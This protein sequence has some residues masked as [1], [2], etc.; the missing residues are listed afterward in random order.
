MY[1]FLLAIAVALLVVVPLLV[2]KKLKA[3]LIVGAAFG[4][5]SLGMCYAIVW[6]L[7]WPFWGFAGF[8]VLLGWAVSVFIV[9]VTDGDKY[10]WTEENRKG[11]ILR[12]RI[13]VGFLMAGVGIFFVRFVAT[14]SMFRAGD[15]ARMIGPVVERVWTQDVQPTSP[16]HVRLVPRELA[17]FLADKQLGTVSGAIGSQ[18]QVSHNLITLQFIKGEYWYVAPLD[19]R[20]FFIWLNTNSTPGYV[21]V[22]GEDP[23]RPVKVIT[24]EKFIYT[25]GAFFG[26]SL[27]RHIWESGYSH[28]VLT[29]YSL[30]V[31]E[32]GK[33]W[34]VVTACQP[35]IGWSGE[36]VRGVIVVDPTSGACTF[37]PMGSVPDWIDRVVPNWIAWDYLSWRGSY[38]NGFWNSVF[39]SKN[40]TK[41]E[42]PTI[43]Y[44]ANHEPLW[45]SCIT[46]DSAS[47]ES[48]IGLV[49]V[50]SRTGKAVE[51]RAA[52][53]TESAVLKAVNNKISFKKWHGADPVLYNIY[54]TMAS[55][56]P[57]LGESG[58]FQGVA[59][60]N[61]KDSQVAIGDDAASAFRGYQQILAQAGNQISPDAARMRRQIEGMVDRF[62]SDVK[63]SASTYY[64]HIKDVPHLFVGGSELSPKLPMTQV[65]DRVV[66][67][68]IDSGE[69]V[70]PML[71]FDNASLLLATPAQK[72]GEQRAGQVREQ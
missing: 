52:G 21:M 44:G 9:F 34:W 43:V 6:S 5:L 60:V 37:Y 11:N 2:A 42:S 46:S 53:N 62:A 24:T 19:Y 38:A 12:R 30:E 40:L 13:V 41:P 16:D 66:I 54:G 61:V 49:Y 10:R 47:D 20:G 17:V 64:V 4:V 29:D 39:G 57:L 36:K 35:T 65:G 56:A 32:Q 3:A 22:N 14:S 63:G 72:E 58:T 31:D 8:L 68:Y 69:D 25:P 23:F 26:K 48:M 15:Y 55:V 28:Y 50:N 59:I 71:S 67:F 45:A 27:E 1:F 7:A 70:L 33:A 51:Y 18:F